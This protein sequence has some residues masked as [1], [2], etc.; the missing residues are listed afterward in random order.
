MPTFEYRDWLAGLI[1]ANVTLLA[2]TP[3][4]Y[5]NARALRPLAYFF[6][7]IMLFNGI[8]H[9]VFTV[10]GHT[11]PSVRFTRPAP[12]FYSSPF[13]FISSIYLLVRLRATRERALT[14]G[15]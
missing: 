4:A 11:V 15:R 9:T 1:L 7:A 6:A 10:L 2:L 13:L 14:D 3:F 12:G 8:G 5:R